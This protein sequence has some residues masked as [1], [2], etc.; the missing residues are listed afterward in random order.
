MLVEVK[1]FNNKGQYLNS[2]VR[3]VEPESPPQIPL[4]EQERH[5]EK[6]AAADSAEMIVDQEYRLTMLELGIA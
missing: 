3:D 5:A 6:V 2:E 1:H 4:V